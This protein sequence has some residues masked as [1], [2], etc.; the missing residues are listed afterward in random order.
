MLCSLPQMLQCYISNPHGF[1]QFTLLR[2]VGMTPRPAAGG[3]TRLL[4]PF[5]QLFLWYPN[6]YPITNRYN[7]WLTNR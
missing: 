1:L 4:V 5:P 2:D 6:A 7:L 3:F